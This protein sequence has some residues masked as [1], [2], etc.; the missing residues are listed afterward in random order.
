MAEGAVEDQLRTMALALSRH[1]VE[2]A[3][4]LVDLPDRTMV[5]TSS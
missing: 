2:L 5:S 1:S 4:D 3:V